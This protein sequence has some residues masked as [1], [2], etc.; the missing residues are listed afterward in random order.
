MG[1][2][3]LVGPTVGL[4]AVLDQISK[5][6]VWQWLRPLGRLEVVPGLFDLTLVLNPGVA[7]GMLAGLSDTLRITLLTAAVLVALTVFIY[8][9]TITDPGERWLLFA[10]SLVCGGAV[11]N[12]I[13]RLRLGKVIDFLDVYVGTHHW[14]A[15]NV[16]DAAITVGACLIA[17]Q[18]FRA[19]RPQ[20]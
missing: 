20:G 16:A 12:Q 1:K 4:V 15:F 19:A 7:F 14:P 10:L 2:W 17:L 5:M 18:L 3:A 8:F 9:I 13:D 6:A 11:G